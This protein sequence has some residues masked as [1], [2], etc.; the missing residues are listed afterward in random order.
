MPDFAALLQQGA[1]QAWLFVPSAILLGAL[2][3]LEPGHSKTM[4][5]AFI[6]AIRG[7]VLQA[8]LLGLAATVSH[9]LVVWVV[10][11]AGLRLGQGWD[12][13]TTEPYFQVA[14]AVLIVGVALWMMARTWREQHPHHDHH[15][16][17]DHGGHGHSH[18][19]DLHHGHHHHDDEPEDAHAQA[20][21]EEIRRRFDGR[22]V[23]TGQI[24][25]FGLTGGLIPCPAAITVLLLCL[26][27]KEIALG[28]VLVLCFSIGLALTLMSAGVV[29]ALGVRHAERRWSGAFGRI[30]RRAPYV[31][32]VLILAVGLYVGLHGLSGLGYHLAA[33]PSPSSAGFFQ[34][35]G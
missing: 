27:L 17:H 16:H 31:S 28:G 30:A 21:A 26:Q 20:H 4:M 14:S 24:V 34:Q 22:P 1:G 33:S 25:L 13:A 10:A 3:G 12:A 18:D 6:V 7:T 15:H 9:T 29:A 5:A 35:I 8:V 32:G 23:T 2:H 11:L 19:H